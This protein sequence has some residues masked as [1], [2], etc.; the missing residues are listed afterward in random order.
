MSRSDAHAVCSSSIAP[1]TITDRVAP[2]RPV[3]RLASRRSAR[4]ACATAIVVC[5][6]CCVVRVGTSTSREHTGS[7][8]NWAFSYATRHGTVGNLVCGAIVKPQEAGYGDQEG[9]VGRAFVGARSE[10]GVFQGWA[11]RRA[12]ESAGRARLERGT[13]RPSRRPCGGGQG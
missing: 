13:G 4:R 5:M 6:C 7:T 1:L 9:H 11:F 3:S 8:M 2:I 12:E 10:G